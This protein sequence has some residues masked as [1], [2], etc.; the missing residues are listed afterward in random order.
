MGFQRF[1]NEKVFNGHTG[2]P[3]T[4]KVFV[5]PVYRPTSLILVLR[6]TRSTPKGFDENRRRKL[7]LA[8]FGSP[9]NRKQ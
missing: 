5:G 7:P 4:N 6:N 9:V 8:V 2:R 1:G 3:L